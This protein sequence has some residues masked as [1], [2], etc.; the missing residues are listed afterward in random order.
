MPVYL[1]FLQV[2][3]NNLQLA[4]RGEASS[5]AGS[6]PRSL[7]GKWT[8]AGDRGNFW[9]IRPHRVNFGN[10]KHIITQ[11]AGYF[12][13]Q[14]TKTS[15][16][17]DS[18]CCQ[19]KSLNVHKTNIKCSQKVHEFQLLTQ[20]TTKRLISQVIYKSVSGSLSESALA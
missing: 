17:W 16:F 15:R 7:R 19:I 9:A 10:R 1:L 6:G 13:Y 3:K 14:A 8:T 2:T 5:R 4:L 18:Q 11:G 20:N 12:T